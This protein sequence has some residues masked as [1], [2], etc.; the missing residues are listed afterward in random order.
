[1]LSTKV[2][3]LDAYDASQVGFPT[4]RG[5][6]CRAQFRKFSQCVCVVD[7][8][9]M[10][11]QGARRRRLTRCVI[12]TLHIIKGRRDSFQLTRVRRPTEFLSGPRSSCSRWPSRLGCCWRCSRS[13]DGLE[14]SRRYRKPLLPP[15]PRPPPTRLKRS[16]GA[17]RSSASPRFI[18]GSRRQVRSST[19]HT[20][21]WSVVDLGRREIALRA[22]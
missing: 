8:R 22:P 19:F 5:V 13:I 7:P 21:S 3:P 1:M 12:Y 9:M 20:F 16:G 14:T 18:H 2:D 4:T 17:R 15:R 10:K 6:G 11:A